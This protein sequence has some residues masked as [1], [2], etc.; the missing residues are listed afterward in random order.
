MAYQLIKINYNQLYHFRLDYL[1]LKAKIFRNL[2]VVI[3]NF[4]SKFFE[5]Q[6]IVKTEVKANIETTTTNSIKENL[7]N[8]FHF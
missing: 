6:L 7:Y 4:F 1:N 8:F 2:L 5:N 3:K